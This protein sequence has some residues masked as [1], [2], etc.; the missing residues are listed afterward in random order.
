MAGHWLP[1]SPPVTGPE[2]ASLLVAHPVV[3]AHFW[4]TWNGVDRRFDPQF[5]PVREEFAG[6]IEFRSADVDD[7]TLHDVC[8]ECEVVNVPALA[9]FVRGRRVETVIGARSAQELRARF[10]RLVAQAGDA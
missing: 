4:A 2:W 7:P 8:R 3:V 6:R 9:C 5:R 10:S 1:G